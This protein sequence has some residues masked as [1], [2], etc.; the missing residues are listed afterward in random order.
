[1]TRGARRSLDSIGASRLE[2]AERLTTP[3]WYYPALALLVAQMVVVHG[4]LGNLP[5]ASSVLVVVLGT[6]WL[7]RSYTGHTGIVARWPVGPLA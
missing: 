3:R 7:V 4:L 6:G 2:V 1:M 5:A